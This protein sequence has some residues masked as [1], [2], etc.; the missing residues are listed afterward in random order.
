[1]TSL[2][3][4][5]ELTATVDELDEILHAN[6]VQSAEAEMGRHLAIMH[7]LKMIR[8]QLVEM[9]LESQRHYREWLQTHH[10]KRP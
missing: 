4:H 5:S 6:R 10:G 9:Q 1:M 7:A 8:E 2:S 3:S